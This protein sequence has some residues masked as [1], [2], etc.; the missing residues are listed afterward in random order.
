MFIFYGIMHNC[1]IGLYFQ[2]YSILQ[3][4]ISFHWNYRML[5]FCLQFRC[6]SIEQVIKGLFIALHSMRIRMI[7]VFSN[8]KITTLNRNNLTLRI[9]TPR[10]GKTYLALSIK[11]NHPII[12]N[13]QR[14]YY[15]GLLRFRWHHTSDI[16]FVT[17]DI[18]FRNL[19]FSKYMEFPCFV[20]YN[21]YRHCNN[22]AKV[23]W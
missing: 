18:M 7:I 13:N 9:S 11:L 22:I 3:I 15:K 8:S 12:S 2:I 19:I 5:I 10:T 23:K 16:F 4:W 17:Y 1:C 21:L 14:L 6:L 20:S